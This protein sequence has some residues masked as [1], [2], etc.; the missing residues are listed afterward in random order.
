MRRKRRD[1]GDPQ[2]Y[3]RMAQ[4]D[5]IDDVKRM[6]CAAVQH[7]IV[8]GKDRPRLTGKPDEV[9]EVTGEAI[10]ARMTVIHVKLHNGREREFRVEVIESP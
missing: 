6:V 10:S 5:D 3:R 9:A 4:L 1:A 8:T 7:A 2:S